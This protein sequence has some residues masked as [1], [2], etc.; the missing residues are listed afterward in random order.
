[1]WVPPSSVLPMVSTSPS[2]GSPVELGEEYRMGL[3]LRSGKVAKA[4]VQIS[5]AAQLRF[6]FGVPRQAR[7]AGV[8]GSLEVV[9]NADGRSPIREVF[10][11]KDLIAWNEARLDLLSLIHI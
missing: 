5:S 9:V 6:S 1:M 7:F 11:L 10:Q 8:G 2:K 3:C 4:Q